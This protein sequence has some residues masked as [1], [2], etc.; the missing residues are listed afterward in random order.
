MLT[1]LKLAAK[2]AWNRRLTLSMMLISIALSITLL[3]GV[4]RLRQDARSGFEQSISGTE[5]IIG[6][7]TS[8]VQ[9]MLYAGFSLGGATNNISWASCKEVEEQP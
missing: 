7:R 8:H 9:V 3:L 6:A 1:I 5:L 4:E 2:S